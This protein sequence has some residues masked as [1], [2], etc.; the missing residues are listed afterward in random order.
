MSRRLVIVESPTKAKTLKRFLAHG[1]PVMIEEGYILDTAYWPDDDRWLGAWIGGRFQRASTVG[2][3]FDANVST[4]NAGVFVPLP[5][6][7]TFDF[8]GEWSWEDYSRPSTI[9]VD[10]SERFDFVQRYLF[11]LT[12]QIDV[13]L[14]IRAEVNLI[15]DDSNVLDRLKEMRADPD[16]PLSKMVHDQLME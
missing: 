14:E 1:M 7:L 11:G 13:N 10:R 16:N 6:D 15:F 3:D 8:T 12:K 2:E 4:L 9:D 5:W